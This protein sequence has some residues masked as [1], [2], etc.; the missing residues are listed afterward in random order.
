[1]DEMDATTPENLSTPGAPADAKPECAPAATIPPPLAAQTKGDAKHDVGAQEVETSGTEPEM[2]PTICEATLAC[3]SRMTEQ[4]SDHPDHAASAATSTSGTQVDADSGV[5][6]Q[7][8]AECSVQEQLLGNVE[9][10]D[11]DGVAMATCVGEANENALTSANPETCRRPQ[12]TWIAP[13]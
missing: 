12:S 6:Q 4:P 8:S 5:A 10:G 11:V 2:S 3:D 1:M 13:Y 7:E 9:T